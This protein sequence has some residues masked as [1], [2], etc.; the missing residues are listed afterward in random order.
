M[1]HGQGIPHN[2]NYVHLFSYVSLSSLQFMPHFVIIS[3]LFCWVANEKYK[4]F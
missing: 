1:A 2:A 3:H 4:T